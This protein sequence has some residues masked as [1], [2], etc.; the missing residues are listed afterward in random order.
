MRAL[1]A[2]WKWCRAGS[3]LGETRKYRLLTSSFG[4]NNKNRNINIFWVNLEIY[5]L[6]ALSACYHNNFMKLKPLD[7]IIKITVERHCIMRHEF[8]F[9]SLFFFNKKI[10]CVNWPLYTYNFSSNSGFISGYNKTSGLSNWEFLSKH[11]KKW[12][13]IEIDTRCKTTKV[14]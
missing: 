10:F 1:I 9:F 7:D 5:P 12:R 13:K 3:E 14:Q 11:K 4:R 6:Q 8:I 2:G